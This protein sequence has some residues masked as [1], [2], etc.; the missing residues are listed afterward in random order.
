MWNKQK[1]CGQLQN[2][3]RIANFRGERNYHSFKIFVFL[4]GLIVKSIPPTTEN[5][6]RK[7]CNNRMN[8]GTTTR[9]LR[10]SMRQTTSTTSAATWTRAKCT[11][12]EHALRARNLCHTLWCRVTCTSW[13]KSESRHL[14]SMYMCVSPWVHL[15]HFLLRSVLHRPLPFLSSRALRA[16][17]WA[18]Q[19]DRHAKPAVLREQG[20]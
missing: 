9:A 20:D 11:S 8:D 15:S 19:P 5:W 13:L 10:T 7:R 1:Y 14:P 3:V 4:H 6:L 2:H 16:A 17:H 12:P 18:R